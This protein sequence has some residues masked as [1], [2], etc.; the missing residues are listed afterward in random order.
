MSWDGRWLLLILRVPEQRR[1]LRH[2]LT[3]QLA[4]A[5]LGRSAT[6]C[7][8]RR[9]STAKRWWPP[10][11]GAAALVSRGA[12]RAR[13]HGPRD[14]RGLGPAGPARA[15]RAVRRRLR[16]GAARRRR[17][18]SPCRLRSC[19][20]GG[21]SRSS[22]P[23][24]RTTCC[25]PTGRAAR[26]RAVQRTPRALGPGRPG[27]LRLARATVSREAHLR[28]LLRRHDRHALDR[29]GYASG[30]VTSPPWSA[31]PRSSTPP[32]CPTWSSPST[33]AAGL[34][35][36][37]PGR[38]AA[39]RP[40]HR[41]AQGRVRRLRRPARHRHDG[42][43]VLRA[44]LPA[45]RPQPAG[46]GDRLADPARRAALRRPPE[47]AD[48]R[49]WWP[50]ATTCA[51]SASSWAPRSC[52]AARAIKASASG[53]EAF[54]SPE[55]CRR[56]APPAWRS[57]VAEARLRAD[58]DHRDVALPATLDAPGR[59]AAAVPRHAR[60]AAARG[61]G[62]AAPGLALEAYGAGNLP[63]TTRRCWKRSPRARAAAWWCSSSASASTG[64][65]IW[66]RTRPARRSWRPAPSAG[67]T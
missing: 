50:R 13:R 43:H 66:A 48:P 67:S 58:P 36:A 24:S 18:R 59:P 22:I 7:G 55:H 9:T 38:L 14:R 21:G 41:P 20:P 30:R 6:G 57:R 52:A 25:R 12:R 31:R 42:L 2:Q 34:A 27:A 51:R 44:G 28:R 35:N 53:F 11:A 1:E 10:R 56:S 17:R 16:P 29:S 62:R 3:T 19:T 8:S 26:L 4:W 15:L 40:R 49:C 63:E 39:D 60:G 46:G 33:T 37:R 54:E 64:G 61:A 65:W 47:P 45:A 5:G 23:T 32:T